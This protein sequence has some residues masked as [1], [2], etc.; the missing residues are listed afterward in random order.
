MR[1]HRLSEEVANQIAAGEVVERP[2]SA[3]KELVENALDAEASRV[4]VRV[5][6]GGRRLIRVRDDGQG[7][8]PEDA[9][10][11][12]ERHAT[13]KISRLEDID[14]ISTMGFRG[15]ALPSIASVSR[16]RLTTRRAEDEEGVR[17]EVEGGAVRAPQQV[18]APAGTQVDVEALFYNVP[19]RLKFMKRAGTEMGHVSEALTR[20]ALAWP[21]VAFRLESGDRVVLDAPAEIQADP[22]GRLGRILGR[23]AAERLVAVPPDDRSHRI[24]VSGWI[25]EPG[26]HERTSRSLYVYVNGRFVRDRGVHHAIQEA[27]RGHLERG[28]FPVVVL[29]LALPPGSFDV[30]VH[31]QKTEVRFASPQDVH[32]AVVGA[33]GR[34]LSASPW[35]V[36]PAALVQSVERASPARSAPGLRSPEE[37]APGPAPAEAA[38]R[39]S[40]FPPRKSWP[41]SARDTLRPETGYVS[42]AAEPTLRLASSGLV[43]GRYLL[44]EEEGR[45]YLVD[46]RAAAEKARWID[47]ETQPQSAAQPLLVPVLVQLDPRRAAS[48]IEGLE[49][50]EAMGVS[51]SDYGAHTIAVSTAPAGCTAE[52]VEALLV[53]LADEAGRTRADQRR[54]AM[55]RRLARAVR[56]PRE[57]SWAPPLLARLARDARLRTGLDGARTLV[58]LEAGALRRLFERD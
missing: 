57:L 23:S 46:G 54:E 11:A 34:T 37:P 26:F 28:R 58:E 56:L 13:S 40:M 49:E 39:R 27:Y 47:L 12:L 4:Q 41:G 51:C 43:L 22:R 36:E 55:R 20:L 21:R 3:V 44:A 7:M 15:E 52:E 18:G 19:A 45:A 8:A 48:L 6:E 16:F 10:T 25:S 32:R 42:G 35:R 31:P 53:D 2:A 29:H 9:V 17:I 24:D 30:N 38:G 14:A 5:E 50:L 1:I 33:L